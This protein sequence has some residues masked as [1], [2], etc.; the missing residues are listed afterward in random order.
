MHSLDAFA[1]EYLRCRRLADAQIDSGLYFSLL[2]HQPLPSGI[3]RNFPGTARSG[4]RLSNDYEG[5]ACVLFSPGGLAIG[6]QVRLTD[7]S[8]RGRYR[9]LCG[10]NGQNSSHLQNGELPLTFVRPARISRQNPAIVEGTGIKP[11]LA[12]DL[13]GQIV[14]GASGGQHVASPVQLS[15]YLEAAVR[16]MRCDRD[17]DI[18]PDAGDIGN[19]HV[20]L[21]LERLARHLH[22]LGYAVRVGWWRQVAKEAPD[23]DELGNVSRIVYLPWSR[24]A[25]LLQGSEANRPF[26]SVIKA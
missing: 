3:P 4:C 25:P 2:R 9:W 20:C 13:L 22:D 16:E 7:C 23:I 12:A 18:Y 21:R 11:R 14:I 15:L 26:D 5:I 24:F 10:P 8:F 1:L 17:I 19:S 6:I